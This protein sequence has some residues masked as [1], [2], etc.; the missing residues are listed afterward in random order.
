M[1]SKE[2]ALIE[3]TKWMDVMGI[4]EINR[5]KEH[6]QSLVAILVK[7]VCD[8]ILIFNENETLTQILKT[9]LGDG[10]TKEIVYD[11]R[12]EIGD[13]Q[14]KTKGTNVFDDE[15]E[16]RVAR[17]SLISAA[18]YPTALFKKLKREDY[19]IASALTVFF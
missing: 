18:K 7:A 17:L 8:D 3:V 10:A 6:T 14:T 5:E 4:P 13:Y 15:V 12:Y 11:F 9:P 16:F 19:L 1:I 2:I